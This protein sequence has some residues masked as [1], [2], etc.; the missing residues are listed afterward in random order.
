ML[1]S[2]GNAEFQIFLGNYIIKNKCTL[3]K[4]SEDLGVTRGVVS[5]AFVKLKSNDEDLFEKANKVKEDAAKIAKANGALKGGEA[6]KQNL[7]R[8]RKTRKVEQIDIETGK[9][10]EI[11]DNIHEAAYDNYLTDSSIYNA[12]SMRKGYINGMLFRYL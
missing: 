8:G 1:K 2:S 10:I 12:M 5:K 4:A 9:T 7:K 6:N 11:Y 3:T